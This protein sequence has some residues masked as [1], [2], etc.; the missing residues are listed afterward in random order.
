MAASV[1]WSFSSAFSV[2]QFAREIPVA[3]SRA[4]EKA[5]WWIEKAMSSSNARYPPPNPSSS[6][7]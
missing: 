7:A 4:R 5:N 6:G 2:A 3:S 1:C